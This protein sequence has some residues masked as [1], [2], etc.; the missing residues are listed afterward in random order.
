M[1]LLVLSTMYSLSILTQNGKVSLYNVIIC[2]TIT[3]RNTVSL[4]SLNHCTAYAEA[5]TF[6]CFTNLMTEIG[7]K[8]TKKL[9]FSQAGIGKSIHHKLAIL[10]LSALTSVVQR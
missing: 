7:D 5:D 2:N 4:S 10:S 6:F 8:F 1:K 9:D 3:V